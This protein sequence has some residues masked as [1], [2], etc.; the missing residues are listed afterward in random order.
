MHQGLSDEKRKEIL[1]KYDLNCDMITE[2]PKVN[3]E[4]QRHLSEIAKKRDQH[5]LDTQNY[6]HGKKTYDQIWDIMTS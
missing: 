1:R 6:V 5:F 4:I 3:L 2:S